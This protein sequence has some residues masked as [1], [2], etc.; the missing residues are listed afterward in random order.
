MRFCKAAALAVITAA[1]PAAAQNFPERG[2]SMVVA[3]SAGGSTDQM[4]RTLAQRLAELWRRPVVVLNRPGAGGNIGAES[5]ARATPDGY[6]LLVGTTALAISPSLYKALGYDAL[7]DLAP[8][9][10][11]AITPNVLVVHPSVPARSVRELIDL[12]RREPGALI[13]ASAGPG[14]SNHMTFVLFAM[15]TKT[16]ILHVPYKGAAPALTAVVG[17]EGAMTFVPISA[18]IPLVKS[19]RLRALGVTTSTRASALPSVPTIA[20][21]GVPGYEASSWTGVLAP[22]ATAPAIVNRIHASIVESMRSPQMR[23][24]M[25]ASGVD[26]LVN[27]PQQFA[28]SLRAEIAKWARVAKAAGLAVQ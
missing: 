23:A 7:K 13:S 9:T 27:T 20:E 10:Q 5:V 18:A 25:Q 4:A 19:G 24:A 17:G 26:P 21:G 2:V 16:D 22:A 14:T 6:T 15:L 1:A 8:V 28:Q 11:L 12:A 3:F